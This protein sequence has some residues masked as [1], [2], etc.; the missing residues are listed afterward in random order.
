MFSGGAYLHISALRKY[1]GSG[2]VAA[3]SSLQSKLEAGMSGAPIF[4]ECAGAES[5][6]ILSGEALIIV[7]YK[8]KK[9]KAA[10]FALNRAEFAVFA[11]NKM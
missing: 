4:P 8:F 1:A 6:I 9:L 2:E 10:C 3:A 7:W 11:M 5:R